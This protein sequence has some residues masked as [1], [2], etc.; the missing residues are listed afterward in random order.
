MCHLLYGCDCGTPFFFA[1][2]LSNTVIWQNQ[3]FIRQLAK[4][5]PAFAEVCL[6]PYGCLSS[7]DLLSVVT[8]YFVIAT[9]ELIL[10]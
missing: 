8:E 5:I 7:E 1:A 4:L 6:A 10:Q 9:A 2:T 3:S